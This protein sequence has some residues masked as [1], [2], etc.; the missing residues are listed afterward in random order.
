MNVVIAKCE[1]MPRVI[2]SS[3]NL[4]HIAPRIVCIMCYIEFISELY[5]ENTIFVLSFAYILRVRFM[6][7]TK[8]S[9][10]PINLQLKYYENVWLLHGFIDTN[11][12][13]L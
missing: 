13:F 7:N 3:M 4:N 5:G 2:L 6:Q 10:E 11:K 9:D 12:R 8:Q 1:W